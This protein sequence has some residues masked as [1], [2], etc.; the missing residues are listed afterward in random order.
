[1]DM[2]ASD[3]LLLHEFDDLTLRVKRTIPLLNT[4]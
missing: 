2:A 4:P 3:I 1:M